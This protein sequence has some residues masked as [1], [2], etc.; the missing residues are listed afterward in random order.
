MLSQQTRSCFRLVL[1]GRSQ[2]DFDLIA[3]IT[4]FTVTINLNLN[5]LILN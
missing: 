3:P 5:Q 1:P 4:V 2:D